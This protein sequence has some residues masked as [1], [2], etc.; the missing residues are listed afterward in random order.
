MNTKIRDMIVTNAAAI[1]A[2]LLLSGLMLLLLHINPVE[3]FVYSIHTM[4]TDKY[5]M[6]EVFLK[7]TP[8]IFTALAFAFTFK[9]NLFNIGARDSFI[10]AP[11]Q[12]LPCLCGLTERYQQRPFDP[13][14]PDSGTFRRDYGG[15]DRIFKGAL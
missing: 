13:C 9:A 8:L 12:P 7:A 14:V 2:G 15:F 1:I 3:V 4:F 10:W 11:L 5:T 6:G